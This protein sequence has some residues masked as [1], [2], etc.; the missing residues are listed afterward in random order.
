[1]EAVWIQAFQDSE[2][3]LAVPGFERS[4]HCLFLVTGGLFLE[5]GGLFLKTGFPSHCKFSHPQMRKIAS[6]IDAT[7]D[8]RN[9]C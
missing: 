4:L 9:T 2:N 5:T 3:Q 7:T 8:F 1:M 6:I